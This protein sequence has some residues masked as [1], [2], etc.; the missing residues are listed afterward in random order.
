MEVIADVGVTLVFLNPFPPITS[1][2]HDR[3]LPQEDI[4]YNPSKS[5]ISLHSS[6]SKEMFLINSSFVIFSNF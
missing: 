1:L 6:P 5:L 2:E 3:I 4:I